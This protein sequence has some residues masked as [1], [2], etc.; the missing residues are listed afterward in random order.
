MFCNVNGSVNSKNMK[1]LLL[2]LFAVS[3]FF[4]CQ[5][6]GGQKRLDNGYDYYSYVKTGQPPAV[7]GQVVILDIEIIDDVGESLD[8]SRNA[9]QRPSFMIPEKMTPELISNPILGLI[10]IM[11]VGDSAMVRV[12]LDS[13][14]N[15][16]ENFQH[17]AYVDY[18]IKVHNIQE[19]QEY[20]SQQQQLKT[21]LETEKKIEAETIFNAYTAGTLKSEDTITPSGVK[22]S[23]VNDT[24]GVLA[25]EPGDLVFVHYY[26]FLRDGTSFDNSYR[27][28]RSFSFTIGKPGVIQGWQ[29]GVPLVPKGGSAILDIPYERGYGA[30]GSPPVIPGEAD[31]VFYVEVE[32][33]VK[34]NK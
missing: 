14:T 4:A 28:G 2:L 9:S 18:M 13:L 30:A 17:S 12:P 5:S 10:N 8:D 23:L 19:A 26:G 29:D 6:D 25:N 1:Y 24:G 22:V 16:P 33:V 7:K 11:G 15:A 32:N 31:L 20:Q 21:E 3:L 27:T 34:G